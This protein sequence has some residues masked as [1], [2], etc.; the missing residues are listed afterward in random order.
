MAEIAYQLEHFA[1]RE[2]E[3]EAPR[4]RVSKRERSEATAQTL[5]MVRVLLVS[6]AFVVLVCGVLYTQAKVTELQGQ[7]TTKSKELVEAEALSAYLSYELEGMSNLRNIEE[8][9]AELGLEKINA[10]QI[11]YVRVDEGNTIEVKENP[12]F[13]LF[14]KAKTG[15]LNAMDTMSPPLAEDD[16]Q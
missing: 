13:S 8:K 5:R 6:V 3:Q 4:V 12:L 7:I 16:T 10:N 11:R 14:G 2:K 1:P 9:A 15:L